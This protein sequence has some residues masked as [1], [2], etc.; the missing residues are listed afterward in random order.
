MSCTSKVCLFLAL[1]YVVA[2]VFRAESDE[3]GTT[4]EEK[5][6]DVEEKVPVEDSAQEEGGSDVLVLTKANFDNVVHEKDII[7]VEFYA[8][9]CGHC[10]SLAP[11][12]EKAAT[13]LKENDPPVPLAKVDAT[14]ETD[15]AS[16]FD[17]SGYPTLKIFR[18]GDVI[19]Y[20]GPRDADGI[21]NYMKERA[22]PNWKPPPE[23][24]ITLTKDTFDDHVQNE[25]LTLVEFY[26][27]WCGHCKRLAPEYEKAAQVLKKQD[28]PILLAK[29][30]ATE[31]TSLAE[32]YGVTG[33][34]TL[35]MFRKGKVFDYDGPRE[36]YGIVDFM[37]KQSGPPSTELFSMKEV[38]THQHFNDITVL[39]VFDSNDQEPFDIFM[40]AA[41]KLRDEFVVAHTFLEDARS[42]Y[43]GV[44]VALFQPEKFLSKYEPKFHFKTDYKTSEEVVEFL[45]D[46]CIPLVGE[47]THDMK[48]HYKKRP[49]LVA[50]Y[51]V[52]WSFDHRVATQFWRKKIL[53]VAK[54]Y[55]D[56]TFAIA[57]ENSFSD[58][59]KQ[60]GLD[61][62]GGDVAVGIWADKNT[63]Y[64]ME[65]DELDEDTLTEFVD[66]FKAGSLKP[67][68]K[69]Q[70][71][72]KK[73]SGPVTVVVGKSFN[74][75]VMDP[76]KDVLIEFYAPW[77]GHC[78][79]LEPKYKELGK[80][81]KNE[82]DLVIAKMDA[83]ANDV[84]SGF[85]VEGFP[86]IYFAAKGENKTPKKYDGGREVDDFVKFLEEN[87]EVL[88]GKGK[89]EL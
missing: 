66:A 9:W 30:D 82:K 11:E 58:E 52:D 54:D 38:D 4:L 20:D 21:V 47:V 18:K 83:T 57:D 22:D 64:R 2:P 79:N 89:D 19:D 69:S 27:P 25:D 75:V 48:R 87:S 35:K 51:T 59:L 81:Y 55:R 36:Q 72:P 39:G 29:V 78:K 86:T 7:L 45:R 84:P 56:I 1:L 71:I 15:L 32:R 34:P 80:K 43:G 37:T 41:N 17:V 13:T 16:R 63:K 88:K 44:G 68:V 12:Y 40:E 33:Y 70:P 8:P 67:V 62:A 6:A 46:V 5:E 3:E 53:E 73:N 14:V 74:D 49:L 10:K 28:P 50:Y 77:C 76:Q 24:V 31:E 26:A 65:E 60:L 85:N 42:R 23:A 61:D